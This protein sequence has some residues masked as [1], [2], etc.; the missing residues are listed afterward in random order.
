M[1]D[2]ANESHEIEI[3]SDPAAVAPVRQRVTAHL[4]EHGFAEDD[5]RR[6]ALALM[7][8]LA[9]AIHH[10]NGGDP[11]RKVRIAYGTADGVF[12]IR[13]RDEGNGFDPQAVPDPRRPENVE[14]PRGRGLLLMRHFMNWVVH[15]G[16]GNELLMWKRRGEGGP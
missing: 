13:V 1:A 3:P 11:G 12:S 6:I 15:L 9:N 14:R 5:V 4:R 2:T 16:G 10:G 8:A 7:E